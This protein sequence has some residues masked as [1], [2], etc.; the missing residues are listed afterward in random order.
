MVKR[1][2]RKLVSQHHENLKLASAHGKLPYY[3]P[4]LVIPLHIK[5][6]RFT[7]FTES[8]DASKDSQRTLCQYIL[9]DPYTQLLRPFIIQMLKLSL[10]ASMKKTCFD[11]SSAK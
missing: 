1:S 6:L 3:Y 2:D 11:Y 10:S 8:T 9:V 4:S 7:G 5:M